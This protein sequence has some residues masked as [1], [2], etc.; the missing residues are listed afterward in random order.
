MKIPITKY[1]LPQVVIYPG[2]CVLAM[3]A[4]SVL[5]AVNISVFWVIEVVL[6]IVLI[7]LLSFFRDPNRK[8]PAGD[9]LILSPADGTISDI[10]VVDEPNF[11]G[12]KAIRIGIFLSI[13]SVHINRTP[14]AVK[15]EKITYRK[16]SFINAMNPESGKVNESND[17]A[18][19]RL[20]KPNEK[21]LVRQISGAIARRIVCDA[22]GGQEFAGGTIFGMIKFGSRTELYLPAESPAKIIVK[23]G[24]K[25]K[26]GLSILAQYGRTD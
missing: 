10:E 18:M 1:G 20:A 21:I 5:A 24:D 25:V 8:I 12:G 26:A 3:A 22:E 7:W 2:L 17:I 6:A 16:G 13:F 11:I 4:A 23:K 15:I 19:T 14:C 9:N